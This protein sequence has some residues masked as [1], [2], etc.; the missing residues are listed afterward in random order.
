VVYFLEEGVYPSD[1]DSRQEGLFEGL[2]GQPRL[3]DGVAHFLDNRF[4]HRAKIYAKEYL[5]TIDARSY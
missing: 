1:G 3:C 4:C 5:Y 2:R